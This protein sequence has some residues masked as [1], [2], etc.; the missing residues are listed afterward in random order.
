MSIE[1]E[2]LAIMRMEKAAAEVG[3]PAEFLKDSEIQVEA[4]LADDEH[5]YYVGRFD[6]KQ[7]ELLRETESWAAAGCE[8]HLEEFCYFNLS[9]SALKWLFSQKEE[10]M[11][12]IKFYIA[13]SRGK[14]TYGVPYRTTTPY[15]NDI[16]VAEYEATLADSYDKYWDIIHEEGFDKKIKQALAAVEGM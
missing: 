7:W 8:N 13:V 9:R 3:I 5:I 6:G 16:V 2:L 1:H 14:S 12:T 4:S 15:Y 11:P 10:T